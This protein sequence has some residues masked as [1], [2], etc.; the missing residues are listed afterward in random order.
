MI[1]NRIMIDLINRQISFNLDC[2]TPCDA[3][4]LMTFP[5]VNTPVRHFVFLNCDV[6][7]KHHN[8]SFAILY[9]LIANDLIDVINVQIS[10]ILDC[11]APCEVTWLL[12]H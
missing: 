2:L 12:G 9:D 10:F 1:A 7:C 8:L 11:L 3:G 6:R 5:N 4:G